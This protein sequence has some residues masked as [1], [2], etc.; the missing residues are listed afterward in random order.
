[1]FEGTDWNFATLQRIHDACEEI[2][3][4]EL[5]LNTY[6]NQIEVI[7]SEQMLDA[8]VS[9]GLPQLYKHW[10]FG[11]HFAHEEASYRRGLKGLAYELRTVNIRNG[12]QR[13]ADYRVYSPIGSGAIE[14]DTGR[15][16]KPTRRI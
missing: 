15:S 6:P 7:T 13:S 1:L 4:Y 10:S 2:A 3:R 14:Y 5:G 8:Y 11:K 16:R 12:E 9:G